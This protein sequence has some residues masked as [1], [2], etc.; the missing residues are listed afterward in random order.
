MINYFFFFVFNLILFMNHVSIAKM[1]NLYD[2]PDKVRKKHKNPTALLGGLLIYLN[3]IL[4]I[5]Q[6]FLAG[7][8]KYFF[9]KTNELIIFFISSTFFYLLG[10]FDDKYHVKANYKLLFTSILIILIMF[11]DES[12]IITDVKI[13]F[14]DH[15]LNLGSLSYFFTVLCFLL[16]IN[17]YN[18]LD[19]IN[20]QAS[21]YSVFI[22]I[23]FVLSKID[24]YFL[25]IPLLFFLIFN[26]KGK[27]FLGDSGTMLVGFIISYFFIKTANSYE[28][29]FS[30]EIFLIMMIPGFELLR[31][32]VTRIIKKKHPFKPDTNH[33]HHYVQKKFDFKKT[34]F[35]VQIVLTLPFISYL[36]LDNIILS[37]IIGSIVYISVIKLFTKNYVN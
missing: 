23:I 3:L 28:I 32:A 14:S 15:Q 2:F 26:L 11:F 20:G 8:E 17:A 29:F 13:K 4:F 19:G 10:Y 6:Y 5:L 25:L 30:D 34:F 21:S 12:L 16:F 1:Y 31:L 36:L 22:L 9:L 37:F 27:M 18:M 33:I 35:I 7:T 24:L